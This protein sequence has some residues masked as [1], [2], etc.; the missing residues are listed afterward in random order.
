MKK[1]VSEEA[2]TTILEA[3]ITS[4]TPI[5]AVKEG[6]IVG[7][8]IHE[9]CGWILRKP[10]GMG[11]YGHSSTREESMAEGARYSYSFC[12]E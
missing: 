10:N 4:G 11:A 5:L 9:D 8:L 6:K 1:V 12:T 7:M 3:T 2:V